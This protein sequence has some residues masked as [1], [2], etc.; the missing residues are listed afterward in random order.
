LLIAFVAWVLIVPDGTFALIVAVSAHDGPDMPARSLAAD[1]SP[2]RDR[3]RLE[4]LRLARAPSP[5]MVAQGAQRERT[6]PGRHPVFLGALIGFG[7]GLTMAATSG[8]R[9]SSD[10]TCTQYG[11]V[12]GGLGA[13][14]GAGVGGVVSL[15]LR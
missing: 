8:C 12:L 14:I 7:T 11:A 2:L 1:P 3:I 4:A 13:G 5:D 6:W 10:Y 15:F 9:K